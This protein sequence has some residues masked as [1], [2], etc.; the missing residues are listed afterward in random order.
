[1]SF[2][3]L[4]G[5]VTSAHTLSVIPSTPLQIGWKPHDS[6]PQPKT[7]GSAQYKLADSAPPPLPA[8]VT[9]AAGS[10]GFQLGGGI[11]TTSVKPK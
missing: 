5:F 3:W 9:G 10:E 6:Q 7:R 1:M 4:C 11:A 8:G 2:L